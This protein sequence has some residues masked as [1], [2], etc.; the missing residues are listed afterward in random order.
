MAVAIFSQFLGPNPLRGTLHGPFLTHQS[1][2]ILT[3]FLILLFS[4]YNIELKGRQH[5]K[6]L[7]YNFFSYIFEPKQF[8]FRITRLWRF[9][10]GHHLYMSLCQS[11][12]LSVSHSVRSQLSQKGWL[13]RK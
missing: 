4:L 3:L 12:R 11:V 10:G 2:G 8:T 1:P 9:L 13:Y 5:Q 6:N 7:G